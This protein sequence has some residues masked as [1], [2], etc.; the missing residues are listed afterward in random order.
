MQRWISGYPH[1]PHAWSS[2]HGQGRF[3]CA[4]RP[5]TNAKRTANN[6]TPAGHKSWA[7]VPAFCKRLK[8]CS[9]DQADERRPLMTSIHRSFATPLFLSAIM[10]QRYSYICVWTPSRK[11]GKDHRLMDLAAQNEV[12]RALLASP[13]YY[14]A[15]EPLPDVAAMRSHNLQVHWTR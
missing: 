6:K 12:G 1:H 7:C 13:E 2:G 3:Q 8:P 5:M 11:N 15:A 14:P 10:R 9:V 4:E